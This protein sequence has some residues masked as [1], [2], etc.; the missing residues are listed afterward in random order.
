[1]V[2]RLVEHCARSLIVVI[3]GPSPRLFDGESRDVFPVAD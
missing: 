1:M 2:H 3:P